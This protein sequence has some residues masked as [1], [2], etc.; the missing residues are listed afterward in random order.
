MAIE[1][2]VKTKSLFRFEEILKVASS[3]H[4]FCGEMTI[5]LIY[6]RDG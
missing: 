6:T 1:G 5:G 4:N 2:A 3:S